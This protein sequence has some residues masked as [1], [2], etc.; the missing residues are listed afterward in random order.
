VGHRFTFQTRPAP[1]FDGIA[2]CEVLEVVPL[3]RLKYTFTGGSH[4]VQG[5][6]HW[7]DTV[8]TW[9]LT[10]AA[11]GGTRLHLEHAGF[12]ADSEFAFQFMGQGWKG[13]GKADG[14]LAAVLAELED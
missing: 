11:N 1:G 14:R 12:T 3:Q 6:G 5:Y 2:H 10:P 9:T 7:L 4:E 13:L 8:I